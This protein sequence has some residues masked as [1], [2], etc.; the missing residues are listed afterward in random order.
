MILISYLTLLSQKYFYWIKVLLRQAMGKCYFVIKYWKVKRLWWQIESYLKV[1]KK[2][3]FT[4]IKLHWMLLSFNTEFSLSG[5]YYSSIT[6]SFKNNSP[7]LLRFL[8]S[9]NPC[10]NFPCKA[11]RKF[12]H[13]L[14]IF[15]EFS[16][17]S[18]RQYPQNLYFIAAQNC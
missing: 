3:V 6:K 13:P 8:Y 2:K 5:V 7:L 12:N 15:L 1:L 14:F 11:S 17:P 18:R 9:P 10:S 4:H 16:Q